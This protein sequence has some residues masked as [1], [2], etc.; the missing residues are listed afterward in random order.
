MN[1]KGTQENK[2]PS[3]SFENWHAKFV[4]ENLTLK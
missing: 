1:P 2:V 3:K 4:C